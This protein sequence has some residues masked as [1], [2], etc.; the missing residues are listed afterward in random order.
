[1]IIF[2]S[3]SCFNYTLQWLIFSIWTAFEIAYGGK[4][5]LIEFPESLIGGRYI[6]N[7]SHTT[8]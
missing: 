5:S 7:V 6:V 3:V 4:M 1:M 8:P 2:A